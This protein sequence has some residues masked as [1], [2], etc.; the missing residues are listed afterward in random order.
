[1]DALL[2]PKKPA[3]F[4]ASVATAIVALAAYLVWAGYSPWRAGRLGGLTFGTTAAVLFLLVGLYPVRRRLLAWPLQT[5]Q[6]WLQ[7]HIYGGTI[8]LLCVFIHM[9]FVL[10]HGAMGWWLLALSVWAILS[11]LIGVVLQKWIPVVVAGSLRVEALATR[12]SELTARLV[13]DADRVMDGAS[14]RMWSAYQSDIRPALERPDPSWA[15]VVNVQ[16]GRLRYSRSL[17]T[18]DRVG[19]PERTTQLRTIVNEKAELDVHLR[20]QRALRAW[21][22]LHVPFAIVLLGLLGVHIFAVLYF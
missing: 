10:P 16:A 18:L 5:A 6:Q 11:G 19:D 13:I 1:M 2:T 20:L 4:A 14:A 9:G 8:A 15:Y 17:E 22:L 21:L 7:F 12:A 3:W